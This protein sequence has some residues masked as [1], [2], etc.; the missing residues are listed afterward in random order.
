MWR[1]KLHCDNVGGRGPENRLP[2]K[3]R[4]RSDEGNEPGNGPENEL[5]DRSRY[6]KE[7]IRD[8]SSGKLPEK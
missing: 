5:K 8:V 4:K 1:R 3:M 7:G 2:D 6:R